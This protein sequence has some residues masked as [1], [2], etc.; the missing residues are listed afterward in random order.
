MRHVI[1][2]S[3]GDYNGIG[4]EI[5]L[6]AIANLDLNVSTP[7]VYAPMTVMAYYRDLFNLDVSLNPCITVNDI[8][9]DVLNVLEID[10]KHD[11]VPNPGTLTN[12]SGLVAMRSVD[13]AI[14]FTLS[15][16][17]SAMVTAPISKEAV[18]LA[19]YHIPGHT[20]YLAENTNSGR[21]VMMLVSDQLRVALNSVHIPL[22]DVAEYLSATEIKD[23][24]SIVNQSLIDDFSI[25]EPH[26]AVL[27][28][29]P[30]AG[31]GGVIGAEETDIIAPA[32]LQL[33]EQG[34]K[35]DGPFP[36]DGFFGHKRHTHYDAVFAMYHDQGLIPFKLLA[37]G[38]GVNFTAGLPVIR[39]S[40]DHGTAFDIAGKGLAD[41]SSFIEAYAMAVRLSQMRHV[42]QTH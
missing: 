21:V 9:P 26:I 27:G 6:K 4:P 32:L 3:L 1:G 13:M 22:S 35:V 17:T 2:I 8:L 11:P 18:N 16:F 14:D 29:N 42:D 25:P 23:N 24:L 33:R 38:S 39:T 34:M 40:P 36:A 28:L 41:P 31:D 7:V 10:L 19:G 30:H 20:E 12:S 37:F 15:E 5:I